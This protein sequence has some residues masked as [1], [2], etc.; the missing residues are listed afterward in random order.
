MEKPWGLDDTTYINILETVRKPVLYPAT[1]NDVEWVNHKAGDVNILGSPT[2]RPL[3]QRQTAQEPWN[4]CPGEPS[5]VLPWQLQD[6]PTVG[7][8]S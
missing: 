3:I 1:V 8:G 2:I 4:A 6:P 5:D 7:V